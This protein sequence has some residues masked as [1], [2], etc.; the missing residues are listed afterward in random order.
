[1]QTDFND[2]MPHV[3]H[4]NLSSGSFDFVVA[5]LCSDGSF[6]STS[7]VQ[8]HSLGSGVLPFAGS[9]LVLSPSQWSSHVVGKI[10]S[11]IDLDPEDETLRRDSKT[12]LKQEIACAS[13]LS[14]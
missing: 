3:F 5:P 1:M 14:L 2:D 11:W 9:D 6:L 4:F 10:S 12:T 8:K 7:L 13:H